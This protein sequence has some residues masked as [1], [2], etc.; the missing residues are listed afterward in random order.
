MLWAPHL[1]FIWANKL[2][3][4]KHE[5]VIKF[6]AAAHRKVVGKRVFTHVIN[7]LVFQPEQKK[8]FL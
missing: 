2:H 6:K 4:L 3:S 8:A 5:G 1:D 7:E